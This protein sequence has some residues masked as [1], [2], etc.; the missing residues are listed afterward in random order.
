MKTIV[1]ETAAIVVVSLILGTGFHLLRTDGDKGRKIPFVGS[2]PNPFKVMPPPS[3]E[4][5]ST[6]ENKIPSDPKIVNPGVKQP[7][8]DPNNPGSEVVQT[9]PVSKQ[10]PQQKA[11]FQDPDGIIREIRVEEAFEE[12]QNE[13]VFLDA[14]R[15]RYYVEE[16]IEG[17]RAMSVWE[18]SFDDKFSEFINEVELEV[19]YVVYCMS[20]NCE[21]SHMLAERMKGAG[22]TM[23]LVLR[24]GF[25]EWKKAGHPIAA[26]EEIAPGDGEG[27][28]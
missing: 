4:T 6:P 28:Q 10:G 5:P 21:D 8:N 27:D 24:G 18:G 17:A 20:E 3:R 2:Y 19:P 1:I 12:F 26:G 15:T 23:I 9:P 13:T 16:H 7:V 11:G 14:R 25:P 22:F